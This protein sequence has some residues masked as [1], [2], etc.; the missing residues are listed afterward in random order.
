[1]IASLAAL[2]LA[3]S[4]S[5]DGPH[6]VVLGIAQDAGHPQA[7]CRRACCRDAWSTPS[8]RHRVASLGI[9]DGERAWLVDAT[10][11]LP[12]Q[13][14]DL[15][16]DDRTLA[17][18]FLTHGHMGHYTGLLHLG[19]E[20][21]GAAD[22]PVYAMPRMAGVLLGSE[23]WALLTRLDHIEVVRLSDRQGVKLSERV[24]VTP[25]EV[26]HRDELS[27]TVGY[28][29]AGPGRTVAWLPDI[30]KWAQWTTPLEQLL[31]EVDVAYLDATF[32]ADGE[33]AR[34]ISEVPH[35][36]VSETMQRLADRP[37][38]AAKVRFV[39]LNHTNPLLQPGGAAHEALEAA[40]MV[41]A[42]R[43]DVEPL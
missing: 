11:D 37:E 25:F 27:E 16:G 17:G 28:T 2:A 19:R 1:V 18:I 29:I 15:L 33:I 41:R 39:H 24:T 6:V 13:L 36:F 38:L 20:A 4:P 14:H 43:G 5:P 30:D 3:G 12:D 26:P 7:D 9:V 35:P 31:A 40:G 10:P 8:L 32:Y 22:V 21:M 42:T 23:P 34:D